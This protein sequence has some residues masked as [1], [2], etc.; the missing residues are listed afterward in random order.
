VIVRIATEGQ[1]E[2]L[3][4]DEDVLGELDKQAVAGCD[5]GDEEMF[6]AAFARLLDY[7][8]TN[9]RPMPEDQLEAS[10]LILPP[11]DTSLEEAKAEFTGEGLIPG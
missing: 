9:G 1:Y 3:E 4:S 5:A 10:D 2:L 7:V 6:H 11:P 8:R